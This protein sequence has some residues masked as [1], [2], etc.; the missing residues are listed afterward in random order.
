MTLE[1]FLLIIIAGAALW[2]AGTLHDM[3][4]IMKQ[5]DRR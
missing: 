3:L 1:A 4:K 2:C 5:R